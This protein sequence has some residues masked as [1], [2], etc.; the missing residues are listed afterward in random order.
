MEGR[1][2]HVLGQRLT[3]LVPERVGIERPLGGVEGHQ[4]LALIGSAGDHHCTFADAG[5]PQKC[6]LNFA[7]L[8]PEAADLDLS[9]PAAEKLQ[10]ALGQPA[11]IVPTPVEPLALAVRIG[12]EGSSRTLGIV[13]VATADACPGEDELTGCAERHW[14]QVLV[15]DVNVHIINRA[16]NRNTIPAGLAVTAPLIVVCR[17]LAYP[18]S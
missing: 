17:G 2:N 5:H 9:I 3:K 10:L 6:I 14:C 15:D 4:V 12:Q 8:Y 18:P 11:P 13:D 16:A 7:D 1:R